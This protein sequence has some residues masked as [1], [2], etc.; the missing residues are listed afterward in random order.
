MIFQILVALSI[1]L[2]P[3]GSAECQRVRKA[4]ANSTKPFTLEQVWALD[5]T[6]ID[7]LPKPSRFVAEYEPTMWS[8]GKP[9]SAYAKPAKGFASSDWLSLGG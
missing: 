5:A 9:P 7:K 8:R 3:A 2:L 1:A 4:A 6:Y